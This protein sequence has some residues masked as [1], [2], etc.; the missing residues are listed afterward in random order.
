VLSF[1]DQNGITGSYLAGTLTL[2]GS[3][4]R[5]HYESALRSVSYSNTG[6]NPATGVGNGNRNIAFTI[7]DESIASLSKN[8]VIAVANTNDAP[9]LDSAASPVM[10]HVSEDAAAPINGGIAGSTLVSELLVGVSDVDTGAL[11]GIAVTGASDRGT[12]WY[13]IDDGTSWAQISAS[14]SEINALVLHGDARLFFQPAPDVYGTIDDAITFRAWDRSGAVVPSN[15]ASGIDASSH[16][17]QSSFSAASD[18]AAIVVAGIND[19]PSLS[20]KAATGAHHLAGSSS[21]TLLFSDVSIA[22][23][24]EEQRILLVQLRVEGVKDAGKE[25]LVIADK[26]LV[27]ANASSTSF[28]AT[29]TANVTDDGNGVFL[30][31]IE[32][33]GGMTVAEAQT[34]IEGIRYHNVSSSPTLSSSRTIEVIGL[35]DDGGG[36]DTAVLTGLSAHATVQAPPPAPPPLPSQPAPVTTTVD[37]VEVRTSITTNGDGSVTRTLIVPVVTSSRTEQIGNNTLADI[38]LITDTAGTAL[39]TAQVPVGLGL[40]MSGSPVLQTPEDALLSLLKQ[41]TSLTAGEPSDQANLTGGGSG[42]LSGLPGDASLVIQSILGTVSPVA[43]VPTE[44]LTI[45]GTPVSDGTLATALVIDAH[46]LPVGTVIQ[47]QDVDFAAVVGEV[48]L[49]G[50]EGRQHVWGDSAA[51]TIVLGADDDVLHGGGGNDTVGSKGG[52]DLLFG[53]AGNDIV[54]GGDGYDRLS[55]GSGD[56]T[57]FGDAGM[58]AARFDISFASVTLDRK[59]DGTLSVSSTE[60]GKDTLLGI[61]LLHFDD[62]VILVNTPD[63]LSVAAGSFDEVYYLYRYPDVAAAVAQ[64]IFRNGY[65]HY[66]QYGQQEGRQPAIHEVA[67]DEAFY[68]SQNSDVAAAVAQGAFANGYMHYQQYGEREGRDPNAL[69]DEQG[70]RKSN[71]DVDAAIQQGIFDS[72]YD[73]YRAYGEKEGRNPSSWLDIGAYREANPD[74][75]AHGIDP[76]QHY[77]YYGLLEGRKI[78]AADDGLWG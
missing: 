16:G 65:E 26:A 31:S 38:P 57:L 41:I 52:R 64:G 32:V 48:T 39:L 21:G 62:Q 78:V 22:T 34:L 70:Y 69:F 77:L 47:L 58:D 45:R 11:S 35:Q 7:N 6:N 15:G 18:T 56:D 9:V 72:A 51:Q 44:P 68:L 20:A 19:A 2:S 30:V 28:G 63:L 66:E 37:G 17:G 10:S 13:S 42:F 54:F 74:V 59:A 1:T 25:T 53:D 33:G 50:G 23:P 14:V 12:L 27:L 55:G 40:Q 67:F 76:L 61:E 4:T 46:R 24:E 36:T 49:G 73:H 29:G 71:P 43:G 75:A 60:T 3:A 5:E 8:V